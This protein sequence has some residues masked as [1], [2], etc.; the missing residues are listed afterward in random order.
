MYFTLPVWHHGGSTYDYFANTLNMASINLSKPTGYRMH[1]QVEHFNNCALCPHCIYVFCICVRTN[2]DLHHLHQKLI[3]FYSR[4]EK[5]LQ[6]NMDWA[7]KW[8]SLHSIF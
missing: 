5:C 3:D 6:C 2:S 7:F 8:S 1:Q 4:Y